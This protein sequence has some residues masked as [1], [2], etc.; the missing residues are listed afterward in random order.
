MDA[1]GLNRCRRDLA[2]QMCD[3]RRC[4]LE[5]AEAEARGRNK[6][7]GTGIEPA[8]GGGKAKPA[9][10]RR[11][12]L[13]QVGQQ[14]MDRLREERAVNPRRS[15]PAS[16]ETIASAYK[17]KPK[18]RDEILRLDLRQ[19]AEILRQYDADGSAFVEISDDEN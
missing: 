12:K 10:A 5:R 13:V 17:D 3:N 15:L 14:Y 11:T 8:A 4:I 1:L 2:I 18:A 19:D 6:A 9:G 16:P 7:A